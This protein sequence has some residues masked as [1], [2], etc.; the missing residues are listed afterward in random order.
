MQRLLQI[1]FKRF[2]IEISLVGYAGVKAAPSHGA[3]L[4]D[5]DGTMEYPADSYMF[6]LRVLDYYNMNSRPCSAR[7]LLPPI[8]FQGIPFPSEYN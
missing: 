7:L 6:S 8:Q 3:G 1:S 5:R 2:G 4:M